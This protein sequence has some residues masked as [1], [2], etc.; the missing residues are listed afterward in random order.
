[1]IEK[2]PHLRPVPAGA[3]AGALAHAAEPPPDWN[4]VTPPQVRGG[5]TRF[6]SDVIIQL[7]YAPHETVQAAIETA[8]Q[9]GT[10]PESILLDQAAISQDQL[11]RAI[12]V[13]HGLDH[14]DLSVFKVD[15]AAANLI[16]SSNAKRYDAVPISFVNERTV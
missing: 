4:G 8:R 14:I 1:M 5:T 12:A 13:R 16:S 9:Q 3:T 10:T 7:G 11:S 6:L 15:M 2:L